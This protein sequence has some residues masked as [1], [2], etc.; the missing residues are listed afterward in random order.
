MEAIVP[1]HDPLS[2]VVVVLLAD[3]LRQHQGWGWLR[4]VAGATP[5]KDVP[6]LTTVKVMGSGHGGGFSLRP[7]ATHQGLICTFSHFDL[8]LKF[9]DSP[10]VQAYRS[11]ARECALCA[12]RRRRGKAD[13]RRTR[14]RPRAGQR[15]ATAVTARRWFGTTRCN[16]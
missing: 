10:A 16:Y 6:G 11:R 3:F 13:R 5:Y 1:A 12:D 7:S 9:L 14:Q 4:L 2:G 15:G 8:A